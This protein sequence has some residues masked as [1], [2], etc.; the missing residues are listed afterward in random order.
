MILYVKSAAVK[1]I[2]DKNI[3]EICGEV[4]PQFPVFYRVLDFNF[5]EEIKEDIQAGA[6]LDLI[7][8]KYMRASIITRNDDGSI[9]TALDKL[10]DEI[11]LD[12][13]K[14]QTE[15][16]QDSDNP[17]AVSKDFQL[18]TQVFLLSDSEKEELFGSFRLNEILDSY[19]PEEIEEILSS[20]KEGEAVISGSGMDDVWGAMM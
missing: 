19:T 5:T 12:Y 4:H 14:K 3:I 17:E 1:K 8:N 9:R 15:K 13:Q 7:L 16:I 6:L 2:Y 10:W 18:A 11:L 20:R